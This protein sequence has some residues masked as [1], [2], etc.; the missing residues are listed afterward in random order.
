MQFENHK[1]LRVT[2]SRDQTKA[3]YD[4]MS[5]FYDYVAGAF[6]K[7]YRNAALKAFQVK[8][9]ENVLEI[10]FGTGK[11]I[12][13]IARMVGDSGKVYGIDISA[14]MLKVTSKRVKKAGLESRVDLYRGDAT[15]MPYGDSKFDAVFMSFTLELFDTPEIPL[16]LS[17]IK[18]VLTPSG[19]LGVVSL[20]KDYGETIP[21]KIYEWF[22]K[23]FPA[24]IDCRPIFVEQS[25][26]GAGFSLEYQ[27][28][29]KMF[30]IPVNIVTGKSIDSRKI[31]FT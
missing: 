4:K 3:V 20:S 28:C 7:K 19:K 13:Q 15:R 26:K 18:R 24:Y 2:R 10:G 5:R 21:L 6:E 31:V 16:I 27:K 8:E 11:C 17:E 9:G 29:M 25:L 30:G 23:R 22:H 12:E 1:V 14:G